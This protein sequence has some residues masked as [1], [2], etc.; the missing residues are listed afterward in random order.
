MEQ[1]GT[2][3]IIE[4]KGET[5]ALTIQLPKKLWLNAC[6]KF[7]TRTADDGVFDDDDDEHG[8]GDDDEE[9]NER[10]E[11]GE[12]DEPEDFDW[13]QDV[14]SDGD[15]SEDDAGDGGAADEDLPA[16]DPQELLQVFIYFILY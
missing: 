6:K 11:Q 5:D 12:A 16:V 15:N 4:N 1:A 9:F 14:P 10:E 2:L 7:G 13:D 8:C 3:L